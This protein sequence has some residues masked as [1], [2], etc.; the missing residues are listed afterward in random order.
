MIRKGTLFSFKT[1]WLNRCLNL[2]KGVNTMSKIDFEYN[3]ARGDMSKVVTRDGEHKIVGLAYNHLLPSG[4]RVVATLQHKQTGE[5]TTVHFK[6]NGRVG[7]SVSPRDLFLTKSERSGYVNLYKQPNGKAGNKDLTVYKSAE[8]ARA[9][10]SGKR[11]VLATAIPIKWTD[12][13]TA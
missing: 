2:N 7:M 9:A 5:V 13:Q 4:K 1:K 11:N 6:D 10:A 3:K 12:R 8:R